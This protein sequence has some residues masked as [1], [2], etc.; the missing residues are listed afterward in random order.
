MR[1]AVVTD[2]HFGPEALHD[3]KLR[4]LSRLAGRLTREVARDL[5]EAHRPELLVN[6]GDVIEDS[7]REDDLANYGE[8]LAAIAGANAPLLHVAGNHDQVHLSEADLGRLW[9]HQGPLHYSREVGGLHLAILCTRYRPLIDV[10]LPH[11]QIGWLA[12]DLAKTRLPSIVLVHHPLGEMDL[13]GNRWFEREAHLCL[14]ANRAA[15]RQ[16][17][18]RS[19][20][21]VAVL[22]GHAHWSHVAVIDGI[23]YVTLQSLT[24]NLDEDAPGRPARSFAVI[25]VDADCFRLATMGAEPQRFE[26]RRSS[27]G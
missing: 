19:G 13:E 15:I 1:L 5:R 12:Q 22:N 4:K 16:V 8:F 20:K 23:P 2:V 24:E 11:E 14:V 26:L 9:G 7:S 6:L 17:I 3:G 27:K 18:A 10:I 21:V 25:E